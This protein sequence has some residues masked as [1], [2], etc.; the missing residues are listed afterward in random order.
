MTI[1]ADTPT[2][3]MHLKPTFTRLTKQTIKWAA[4]KLL[5]IPA[6]SWKILHTA[7][8]SMP[9]NHMKVPEPHRVQLHSRACP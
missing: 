5:E 2:Q 6:L 1:M 9:P 4:T 3:I 8:P 7:P